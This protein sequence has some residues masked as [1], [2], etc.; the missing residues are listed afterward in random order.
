[1]QEVPVV[2]GSDNS[3]NL[4]LLMLDLKGRKVISSTYIQTPDG[5]DYTFDYEGLAINQSSETY[6]VE[7]KK[8][9][10]FCKNYQV[11]IQNEALNVLLIYEFRVSWSAPDSSDS[12][13][14][15]DFKYNVSVSQIGH[16]HIYFATKP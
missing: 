3:S 4:Y 13:M 1:M 15:K 10:L 6:K 7:S 11:S 14:S 16:K 8:K 12:V 2:A 9:T 5:F